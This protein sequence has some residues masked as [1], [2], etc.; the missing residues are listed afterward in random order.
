MGE[1]CVLR[2]R[3]DSYQLWKPIYQITALQALLC[4]MLRTSR[5]R[6][7]GGPPAPVA[8]GLNSHRAVSLLGSVPVFAEASQSRRRCKDARL[9][10]C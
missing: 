6:A 10:V 7:R 4:L 8:P 1:G 2:P 3:D 5:Q 9:E